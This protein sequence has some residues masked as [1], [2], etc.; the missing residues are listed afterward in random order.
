MKI[1]RFIVVLAVI[2]YAGWLAWPYLS[3]L[4]DGAAPD[5]SVARMEA[6]AQAGGEL[7]G[8]LPAWVLWVA[9]VGLY[10]LAALMLGAGNSRAAAAYF[11]AFVADASLR[12]ALG[13]QGGA[14]V[15]A[16]SSDPTTMATPEALGALPVDPVWLILG[17]LFLLGV[18][19]LVASR[20]VRRRRTAGQLDF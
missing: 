8:F 15:S 6:D 5:A 3:P 7:F 2:G 16:R 11:L 19:V 14:E 17:A 13:R 1:L 9:A 18:L 4:L 20:R 12:L 10:L